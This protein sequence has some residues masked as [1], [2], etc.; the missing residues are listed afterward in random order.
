[1]NPLQMIQKA[2][3]TIAKQMP[4]VEAQLE[5]DTRSML[6]NVIS[7]L[8]EVLGAGQA[9]PPV[10][11]MVEEQIADTSQEDEQVGKEKKIEKPIGD[12]GVDTRLDDQTPIT[13]NALSE[14]GKSLKNLTSILSG[15]NQVQKS[16]AVQPVQQN[17]VMMQTMVDMTKVLK[18]LTDKVNQNQQFMG[19]FMKTIGISDDIVKKAMEP[20]AVTTTPENRPVQNADMMAFMTEV[21]KAVNGKNAGN[22]G[23]GQFQV[24]KQN[25]PWNQRGEVRKSYDPVLDHLLTK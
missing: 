21:M 9:S 24:N 20:P 4:S 19:K 6:I 13:D 5:P 1:M 22:T 15:N 8:Q 23:T 18:S 14:I 16:R 3:A 25:D 2:M 11:T 17:S 7:M 10:E 12:E